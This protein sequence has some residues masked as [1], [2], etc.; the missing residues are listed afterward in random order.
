MNNS[1]VPATRRRRHRPRSR[2]IWVALLVAVCSSLAVLA[3]G[4]SARAALVAHP[5]P[6]LG[7]PVG[8]PLSVSAQGTGAVS[9]A[10]TS[11]F[12]PGSTQAN[13]VN[14]TT[15]DCTYWYPAGSWVELVP[16]PNADLGAHFIG[17][18]TMSGGPACNGYG[19]AGICMFQL[20][21]A[22]SVTA[23]FSVAQ[24]SSKP[25]VTYDPGTGCIS[26]ALYAAPSFTVK[27]SGAGSVAITWGDG[28]APST[29]VGSC[30]YTKLSQ[31]PANTQVALR[32]VA[33]PGWHFDSWQ[34]PSAGCI[35]LPWINSFATCTLRDQETG[36]YPYA[37]PD[38]VAV[39]ARN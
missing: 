26:E 5:K 19:Y 13:Y 28:V 22:T 34:P 38:V 16:T 29:C 24:R 18:T 9:L 8:V 31:L 4:G 21:G 30:R 17:W 3:S 33:A 7:L 37:N 15:D 1:T 39:F 25:C 12:L 14:C 35:A 23:R 2:P 36:E 11:P 6:G 27:T 32:P 20:T 10:S